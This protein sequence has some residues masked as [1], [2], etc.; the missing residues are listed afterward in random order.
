MNAAIAYLRHGVLYYNYETFIPETG[1]GSGEYGPFNHMFPITPVR[2]GEGFVQG[3]ERVVTCVSRTF[4]WPGEDAPKILLFDN[5]GRPKP[6]DMKGIKTD[7]GWQVPVTLD[8]WQE[9]AILEE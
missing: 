6:H 9:I 3:K 7:T 1:P 2:L 5:T 4:D 8:D